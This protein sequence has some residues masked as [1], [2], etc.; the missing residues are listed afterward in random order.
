MSTMFLTQLWRSQFEPYQRVAW[1]L[2][3][4]MEREHR[5][6]VKAILET[7]ACLPGWPPPPGWPGTG[8]ADVPSKA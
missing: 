3:E 2:F 8:N 5:L 6:N 4:A 7:S 1:F